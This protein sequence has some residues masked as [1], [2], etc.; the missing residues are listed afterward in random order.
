MQTDRQ[1][2]TLKGRHTDNSQTA[3]QVEII[4]TYELCCKVLK[5]NKIAAKFLVKTIRNVLGTKLKK[6]FKY[7]KEKRCKQC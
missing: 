3:R 7:K 1:T 5:I 4:N 2:D 6:I